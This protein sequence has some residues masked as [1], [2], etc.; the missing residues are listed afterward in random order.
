MTYHELVTFQLTEMEGFYPLVAATFDFMVYLSIP[1]TVVTI[2]VFID[3]S[4][5]GVINC[6][7]LAKK[8]FDHILSDIRQSYVNNIFASEAQLVRVGV[9]VL[10]IIDIRLNTMHVQNITNRRHVLL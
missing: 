3:L 7:I 2:E 10:I 4:L 8:H 6:Y 5:T 1:K 9:T